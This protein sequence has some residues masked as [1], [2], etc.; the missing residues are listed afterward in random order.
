MMEMSRSGRRPLNGA[1]KLLA[2]C[3]HGLLCLTVLFILEI[4]LQEVTIGMARCHEHSWPFLLLKTRTSEELL[5]P[6]VF[7]GTGGGNSNLVERPQNRILP[8]ANIRTTTE[9]HG[10]DDKLHGRTT[11]ATTLRFPCTQNPWCR[12]SHYCRFGLPAR[13]RR[14]SR[15]NFFNEWLSFAIKYGWRIIYSYSPKVQWGQGKPPASKQGASPRRNSFEDNPPNITGQRML[16]PQLKKLI[17]G[18]QWSHALMN[19]R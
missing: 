7:L 12:W 1:L 2:R 15:F 9:H 17:W 5:A 4:I 16:N 13:R 19:C 10:I 14:K 18:I 6:V 3:I 11:P 8:I